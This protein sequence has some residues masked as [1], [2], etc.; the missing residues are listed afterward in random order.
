[1]A[2][3]RWGCEFEGPWPNTSILKERKG[4]WVIWRRAGSQWDVVDVGESNNVRASLMKDKA[5][6]SLPLG[7]SS[8]HYSATYTPRLSEKARRQLAGRIRKISDHR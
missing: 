3:K 6:P 5:S 1:M 2:F 4:I 7:R 8:I